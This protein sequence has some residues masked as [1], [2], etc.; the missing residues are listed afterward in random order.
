MERLTIQTETGAALKLNGPTTEQ[1]ARKQLMEA[2]KVAI[3]KLAYY[4]DLQ[5]ARQLV[6]LP[7]KVGDSLW[8]NLVNSI[9]FTKAPLLPYKVK[10]IE[11]RI[12]AG[13]LFPKDEIFSIDDIGKIVFLTQQEAQEALDNGKRKQGR[14]CDD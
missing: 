3:N 12:I 6:V 9:T 10:D 7:C 4:E 14:D 11:I 1:E 8:R 5:E 13:G 2:Y